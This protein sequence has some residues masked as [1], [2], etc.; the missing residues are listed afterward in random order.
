MRAMSAVSVP[1]TESAG[2]G[3]AGVPAPGADGR[4]RHRGCY[5]LAL[6]SPETAKGLPEASSP[7]SG[8]V[9]V[10]FNRFGSV[11]K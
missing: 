5:A 3:R 6:V 2:D 4:L 9:R 1:V 11:T 8:V 7:I 10:D